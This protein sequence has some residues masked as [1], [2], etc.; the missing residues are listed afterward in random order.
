MP[1]LIPL[2][3]NPSGTLAPLCSELRYRSCP[4]QKEPRESFGFRFSRKAFTS[5]SLSMTMCRFYI[6]LWKMWDGNDTV[7]S[8]QNCSHRTCATASMVFVSTA[9]SPFFTWERSHL[10]PQRN[11][12][13][14]QRSSIDN[15]E[16][17]AAQLEPPAG[18]NLKKTTL[19]YHS[20]HAQQCI[21]HQQQ[22]SSGSNK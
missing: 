20:W 1:G 3:A 22:S 13:I 6:P 8:C 16:I 14:H 10:S 11:R 4:A 12:W 19:P 18:F 2:S 21:K 9:F 7:E 5:R 17:E 15:L